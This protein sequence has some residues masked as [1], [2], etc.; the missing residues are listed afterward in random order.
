[1]EDLLKKEI[2]ELKSKIL[3]YE[4]N[5]DNQLH[6]IEKLQY[7]TNLNKIEIEY[8][9]EQLKLQTSE[10]KEKINFLERKNDSM[11]ELIDEL[12]RENEN[13]KKTEKLLENKQ[14]EIKM[15]EENNDKQQ[16]Q[17]LEMRSKQLEE[18]QKRSDAIK[19]ISSLEIKINHLVNMKEV[20]EKQGNLWKEKLNSLNVEYL[21]FK[22]EAHNQIFSLKSEIE[23]KKVENEELKLT[24]DHMKEKSIQ[25]S[26]SLQQ[27]L[28]EIQRLSNERIQSEK[29]FRQQLSSVQKLNQKMEEESQN[30]HSLFSQLQNSLDLSQKENEKI[31]SLFT[32]LSQE[33]DVVKNEN[34][35]LKRLN[36]SNEK[37]PEWYLQQN[38]TLQKTQLLKL[39]H[40]L[41][42][43]L[44]KS[45]QK[46][47]HLQQDLSKIHL[48]LSSTQQN[49][50]LLSSQNDKLTLSNNHLQH[51]LSLSLSSINT[52]KQELQQQSLLSSSLQKQ[53]GHL[54]HKQHDLHHLSLLRSP[55]SHSSSSS[56]LFNNDNSNNK[57][58][59]TSVIPDHLIT[60]NDISELQIN[61]MKLIGELEMANRELEKSKT[62]REELEKAKQE[63]EKFRH[64]LD[65]FISEKEKIIKQRDIYKSL[66]DQSILH[67]S[68]SI[69]EENDFS[70]SIQNPN[71]SSFLN[72]TNNNNSSFNNSTVRNT[73]NPLSL[74][75]SAYHTQ[76]KEKKIKT[77]ERELQNLAEQNKKNFENYQVSLQ[78]LQNEKSDLQEKLSQKNNTLLSNEHKAQQLQLQLSSLQNNE[79]SYQKTKMELNQH[80]SSLEQQLS[81]SQ[82]SI[83][84]YH[85]KI[86]QSLSQVDLLNQTISS[87]NSQIEK[88]NENNSFLQSQIQNHSLLSQNVNMLMN[89]MNSVVNTTSSQSQSQNFQFNSLNEKLEQSL[90][91]NK[92]LSLSHEKDKNDH[93]SQIQTLQNN[94]EYLRNHLLEKKSLVTHYQSLYQELSLK[95][96]LLL[97]HSL[98]LPLPSHNE[99]SSTPLPQPTL[100]S[101][102]EEDEKRYREEI[103]KGRKEVER[104]GLEKYHWEQ[105]AKQY[106]NENINLQNAIQILDKKLKSLEGELNKMGELKNKEEEEKQ[107]TTYSLQQSLQ[108]EKTIQQQNSYLNEKLNELQVEHQK[109]LLSL[110]QYQQ[111]IQ[112]L[113]EKA[114][115]EW[116]TKVDILQQLK[117]SKIHAQQLQGQLSKS[118]ND[119]QQHL[120]DIQFLN[121]S[122]KEQSQNHQLSLQNLQSQLDLT[123]QQNSLLYQQL[124]DLQL[125]S[126]SL[127][128]FLYPNESTNLNSSLL[129]TSNFNNT[130]N[131]NEPSTP[132]TPSSSTSSSIPSHLNLS[133]LKQKMRELTS[134]GEGGGGESAGKMWKWIER[135]KDICEMQEREKQILQTNLS[136]SSQSVEKLES[137]K[138]VLLQNLEELKIELKS[139]QNQFSNNLQNQHQQLS[140]QLDSY[141]ILKESNHS[142]L[143][144][145]KPCSE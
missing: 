9:R 123:Q 114:N 43:Q 105:L 15:L 113:E 42:L 144:Q 70:T 37:L 48:S 140:E 84:D 51:Q 54:L 118:Q 55:S 89:Q 88:L 50:D 91:K 138:K 121:N 81:D 52:L 135:F 92:Q 97:K 132:S 33:F 109:T 45:K 5:N 78:T 46:K 66:Y 115:E 142:L 67:P 137:E 104:I 128:S 24:V 108:N 101:L 95:Y 6:T 8:E 125:F 17:L 22:K 145:N 112:Q 93:I 3:V 58:G 13:L 39:N 110:Q 73:T 2:E 79:K 64:L 85:S 107:S 35:N 74:S 53:L 111:Q 11:K 14:N 96:D 61:N 47:L 87:L 75:F 30:K 72:N 71:E 83:L 133:L 82:K 16:K 124:H 23:K 57:E 103:Q 12:T 59:P 34:E 31:N 122:L 38:Y 65:Q 117:S 63:N 80:I 134:E 68:P 131:T 136:L 126:S 77:L 18:E 120:F 99:L 76:L 127:S 49:F 28:D 36:E 27:A 130:N 69:P 21:E 32:Q 60:F 141:N 98:T 62:G 143:Q 20:S 102:T 1:M 4:T 29:E 129:N 25:T 26:K 139:K 19:E 100:L 90:L 10:N 119:V 94:I 44:D 41:Q 106:E 86:N 116:N 40:H 7:D 56:N